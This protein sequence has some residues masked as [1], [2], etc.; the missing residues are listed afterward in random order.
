MKINK[1]K[2][3]FFEEKARLRRG[4]KSTQIISI[5]N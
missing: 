1:T 4:K 3:C 5:R 2:R